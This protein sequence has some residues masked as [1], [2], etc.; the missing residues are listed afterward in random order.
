M[1]DAWITVIGLAVTTAAIRAAGPIALGGRELPPRLSGMID[2]LAPALLSA[3]IVV[4]TVGGDRAIE[5]D[6]RLA[7]VAAAAGLLMIRRSGFLA[8]IFLAAAVTASVRAI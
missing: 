1:S 7:G 2:L 5:I 8:V 3:L 4:Q 6:A